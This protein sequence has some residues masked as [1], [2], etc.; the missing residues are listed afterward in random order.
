MER[1]VG[2]DPQRHLALPAL[3]PAGRLV[4]RQIRVDSGGSAEHCAQDQIEEGGVAKRGG[5][6]GFDQQHASMI[7]PQFRF[8]KGIPRHPLTGH[9]GGPH[10]TPGGGKPAL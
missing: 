6:E 4:D 1:T 9:P 3:V 7:T 8:E 5:M 10:P 2:V